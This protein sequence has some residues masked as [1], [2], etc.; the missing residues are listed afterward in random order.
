MDEME[1]QAVNAILDE[2]SSGLSFFK[3]LAEVKSAR[4]FANM[5][6][7]TMILFG[8]GSRDEW[9][10]YV[11]QCSTM[12]CA[13]PNDLV[14]FRMLQELATVCGPE[15]LYLD[16][17][18]IFEHTDTHL[19]MRMLEHIAQLAQKY[20]YFGEQNRAYRVFMH[21]YYGMVSEE[22]YGCNRFG[23]RVGA[24]PVVFAG[25]LIK[26]LSVHKI[27]RE[28]ADLSVVADACRGKKTEDILSECNRRMIYRF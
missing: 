17:K 23:Q 16:I 10:P 4:D 24:R 22:N 9:C 7:G 28:G 8:L 15:P 3:P 26:M 25:K 20:D 19:D 13:L 12:Q 11:L 21:L 18:H 27:L 1:M 5:G 14:Y 6:D 2:E